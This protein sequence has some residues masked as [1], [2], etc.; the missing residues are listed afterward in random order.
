MKWICFPISISLQLFLIY[1]YIQQGRLQKRIE[2]PS[3]RD[4]IAYYETYSVFTLKI[5]KQ[6]RW[7]II[8]L[9]INFIMVYVI[10]FTDLTNVL[11]DSFKKCEKGQLVSM[12]KNKFNMIWFSYFFWGNLIKSLIGLCIDLNQTYEYLSMLYIII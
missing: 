5:V 8:F 12:L 2:T 6:T 4:G 3:L 9:F 1:L 10:L 11:S 7:L